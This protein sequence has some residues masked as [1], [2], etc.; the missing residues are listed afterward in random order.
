[1]G[2][3]RAHLKLHRHVMGAQQVVEL[4]RP[5]EHEIAITYDKVAADCPH[6][7]MFKERLDLFHVLRRGRDSNKAS[8]RD[9]SGQ[10]H[11]DGQRAPLRV[12]GENDSS[13][14]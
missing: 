10:G 1:M 12:A 5:F 11:P 4:P 14:I 3:A 9:C 6:P 7:G 2:H 13:G 8:Y